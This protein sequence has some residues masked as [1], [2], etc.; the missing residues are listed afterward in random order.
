VALVAA[1]AAGV[2]RALRRSGDVVSSAAVDLAGKWTSM[3][4]GMF[5]CDKRC[6]VATIAPLEESGV[7]SVVAEGGLSMIIDMQRAD[8]GTVQGHGYT[9]VARTPDGGSLTF[10]GA[11]VEPLTL[12]RESPLQ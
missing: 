9:R 3:E 5:A 2:L 10:R 12:R 6:V 1:L 7:F 8:A 4:A 11:G